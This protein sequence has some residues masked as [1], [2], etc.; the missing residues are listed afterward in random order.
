MSEVDQRI[1]VLDTI[2]GTSFLAIR[3]AL[4]VLAPHKL[5]VTKYLIRVVRERDTDM[6]VFTEK[7]PQGGP[8]RAF[9]V[10]L[11]P[12][13]ELNLLEANKLVARLPLLKALDQMDGS[14]YPPIPI[15]YALFEPRKPDLAMYQIR[16]LGKGESVT[17]VFTDKDRKPGTRGAGGRLGFEAEMKAADL[18]VLRS[19]FLK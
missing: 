16:V 6:V 11:A 12:D 1:K 10:R 13:M 5:D 15:A 19:N 4:V 14:N 18:K 7:K 8:A 3:A 17:V 2:Q 9:G